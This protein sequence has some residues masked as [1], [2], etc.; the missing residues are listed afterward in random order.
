MTITKDTKGTKGGAGVA[1]AGRS[2]APEG[3]EAPMPAASVSMPHYTL[4]GMVL[5]EAI[6]IHR[7][8][9]PL[10]LE[11]FYQ[12]IL[13]SRL[14]RRG[15]DVKTEV[16]IAVCDEGVTI[17]LAFRMDLLVNDALVVELKVAEQNKPVYE[18]QL[19]TYMRLS[20]KRYGLLL[21]F[22]LPVLV[23][24]YKHFIL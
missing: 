22:G 2:L 6:A 23:K 18:Q 24:G 21:N 10:L 4:N 17:D 16:P 13:A 11:H 5:D 9:G 12:V 8:Y 1:R 19:L 7:K 3:V 20:G 14:R 15:L